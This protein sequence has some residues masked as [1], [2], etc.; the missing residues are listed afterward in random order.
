MAS[1][2]RRLSGKGVNDKGLRGGHFPAGI[3]RVVR[4]VCQN[5]EL[6]EEGGI[7]CA[8]GGRG[9]EAVWGNASDD[10]SEVRY[11]AVP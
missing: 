5:K 11:K 10:V 9:G 7:E 4:P 3:R 2:D 8:C 6:Q 1:L